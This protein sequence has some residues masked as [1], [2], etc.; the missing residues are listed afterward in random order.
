MWMHSIAK[1]G[2]G[3]VSVLRV[4]RPQSH[5]EFTFVNAK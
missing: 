1:M 4:V 3:D 2:D 5:I